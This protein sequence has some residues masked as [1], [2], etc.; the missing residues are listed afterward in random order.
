MPDRLQLSRKKG[1]RLPLHAKSVARPHKY[2]NPFQVWRN[3]EWYADTWDPER[4]SMGFAV[5][6]HDNLTAR[7]IAAEA[8]DAAVAAHWTGVPSIEEIRAELRGL[9]LAC[10]CPL[11]GPGVIQNDWCHARVLLVVA[12]T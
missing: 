9:S 10:W 6:C 7:K 8:Y 3:R 2:G 1:Y 12:N 11:P 4:Q 5:K